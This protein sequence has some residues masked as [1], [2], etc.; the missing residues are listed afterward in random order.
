MAVKSKITLVAIQ[1]EKKTMA[2][3]QHFSMLLHREEPER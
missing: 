3:Y 1:R 2:G